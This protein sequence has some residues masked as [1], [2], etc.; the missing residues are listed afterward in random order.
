MPWW[1]TFG[2]SLR[3]HVSANIGVRAYSAMAHVP[4]FE[5]GAPGARGSVKL[6]TDAHPVTTYVIC[7]PAKHRLSRRILYLSC[8]NTLNVCIKFAYLASKR[9]RAALNLKHED[10]FQIASDSLAKIARAGKNDPFQRTKIQNVV[11]KGKSSIR[12]A[13]KPNDISSDF[14]PAHWASLSRRT[15]NHHRITACGI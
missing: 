1:D 14:V 10:A 15:S 9:S 2:K 7:K 5:T 4:R 3:L 8:W 12:L 11:P 13:R 6:S